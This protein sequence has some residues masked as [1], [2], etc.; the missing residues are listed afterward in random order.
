MLLQ[1]NSQYLEANIGRVQDSTTNKRVQLKK[2]LRIRITKSPV[3]INYRLY[4]VGVSKSCLCIDCA[5]DVIAL[6]LSMMSST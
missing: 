6:F 2:P 3:L 4:Q 1:G 5:T